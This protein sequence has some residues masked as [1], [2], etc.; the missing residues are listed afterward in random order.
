MIIGEFDMQTNETEQAAVRAAEEWLG[1]VD[2]GNFEES[3]EHASAVFKS[4][5][6]EKDLFKSGV[7][8]Q[9]WQ[10]SLRT[11]Q[12]S[13]GKAVSRRL[14]ARLYTEVLPWEP[15]AEYVVLEYETT[16]ERQMNRTESV[17][18]V[19]ECDGEWRVYGY[20][21]MVSTSN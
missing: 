13:L 11:I 9:Q 5:I 3:W 15:D 20:R 4:G 2:A 21:F 12:D 10:S 1:L 6:S 19:R 16:F 14:K 8:K 7:S 18:M 17:T